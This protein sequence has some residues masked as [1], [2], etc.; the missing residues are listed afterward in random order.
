MK[1]E[2]SRKL[3]T[4]I[5]IQGRRKLRILNNDHVIEDLKIPPGNPFRD[6]K[7]K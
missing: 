1:G 7:W 6:A 4:D 5:Q 3:P 2:Y